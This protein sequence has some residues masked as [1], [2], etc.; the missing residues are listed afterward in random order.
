[1]LSVQI[2]PICYLSVIILSV[3]MLFVNMLSVSNKH[4]M[5]SVIMLSVIMLSVVTPFLHPVT[6]AVELNPANL[7]SLV[8]VL[9]TVLPILA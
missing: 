6:A 5:L 3:I 8:V 7:G 9:P 4:Y 2:N 1:M